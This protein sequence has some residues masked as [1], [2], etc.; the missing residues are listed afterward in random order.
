MSQRIVGLDLGTYSVKVVRL[1]PGKGEGFDVLSYDEQVLAPAEPSMSLADRHLEALR[2]LKER[3][4][5]DGDT[6]LTGLAGDLASLKTLRFPFSDA[7]K[8]EQALPFEL[9]SEI[10]FDIED[11]IYTWTMLGSA[12]KKDG[13]AETEV[14]VGFCRRETLEGHLKLLE[15]VGIDPRHVEFAP[16][17]L[18]DLYASLFMATQES[19]ESAG[20]VVTPG[21]TVIE[22]GPDAAEHGAA[23]VDIGHHQTS[24]CVVTNDGKVVAGHSLLHGGADATRALA[25]EIRLPLDEAER[26]KRKEAFIEVSGAV[27]QFP[28]QHRISEIL[29]GAYAPVV[30]R[31]RQIFQAVLSQ[32]R[33]RVTRVYL[34]GGG[35]RITNLDRHFSEALNLDVVRAKEIAEALESRLPVA[36]DAAAANAQGLVP[37][38]AVAL[39]YATSG[40][41]G[42]KR[43][44]RLDFRTGEFAWK[45]ELEFIQERA[46]ALGIWAL[47]LLLAF[48]VSS[49]AR[50][51]VLGQAEEQ[52]MSRQVEAC[53]TITGQ[54][55][56]SASRCLAIVQERI[57]G[58]AGFRVP[59]DSATDMYLEVSARI[60][61]SAA[62]TRKVT[63]L[64]VTNDRIRIK[65][66]TTDYD[67]VDKIVA[68]LGDGR[69]FADVEKG[70]ARNV[71]DQIEFNVNIRLDCAAAPGKPLPE[72]EKTETSAVKRP[73][74]PT[75]SRPVAPVTDGPEPELGASD[76]DSA[77]E[78]AK[79]ALERAQQRKEALS[80]NRPA[81]PVDP[82]EKM[83]Q[84]RDQKDTLERLKKDGRARDVSRP[85]AGV[86]GALRG[87]RGPRP[88]AAP[89]EAAAPRGPTTE[90]K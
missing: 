27:A 32:S 38:A 86:P 83:R 75:P 50:G 51:Y 41:A 65:G 18:D 78:R 30:R 72:R 39:A 28:E 90:V 80:G 87:I 74:R 26:G 11:V 31:L 33:V 35:S 54:A 67:A 22:S 68:G 8:I 1:E 55:I 23:I 69:C 4:A 81:S 63:E 85:P 12:P 56:D 16:L 24:V 71:K 61:P 34:T 36:A 14:L 3:G 40:L 43:P 17:A 73:T 53:K 29:K 52:L 89:G 2:S 5:L 44:Y 60:P 82:K 88:V 64:D 70:K 10:P 7:R 9:D 25:R 57:E 62:V 13:P 21:G 46:A 79:R 20:P 84:I 15:E 58:T 37:E 45:G 77:R 47:V 66:T 42:E 49:G 76:R 59:D 19:L 6:F 48:A